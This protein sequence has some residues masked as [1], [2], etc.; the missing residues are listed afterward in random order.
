[1]NAVMFLFLLLPG[2]FAQNEEAT[3]GPSVKPAIPRALDFL[4]RDAVAWRTEHNCSSCHHAAMVVWAMNEAKA[5][6]H[7]VDEVVLG[8]LT[9]WLTQAGEGKTGLPR[10]EGRPRALNTKAVY[11]A[12]ALDSVPDPGSKEQEALAKLLTTVASDQM[13]DGSWSSWPETRPP[14]FGN[15]DDSMTALATLAAMSGAA[16]G[17]ETA[18]TTRDRGMKWLTEKEH[19]GDAQSVALRLV[20]FAQLVPSGKDISP[21][22]KHIRDRQNSDGGWSQTRDESSDAWATGQALYALAHTEVALTNPSIVRGR[23]F[24]IR[25]QRP[26]GSWPMKSRPSK[27]GGTGADN[28]IPITGAASAWALLGLVR[29]ENHS[30]GQ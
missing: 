28:L 16:K 26:D 17:H 30:A 24:L 27:P 12:L 9:E 18:K 25:T 8:D 1:V 5:R 21:L 14:I 23:D 19:D 11:Y 4:A 10:P 20:L 22:I 15:S 13:E 2:G 6:G 7:G 3:P 29:T